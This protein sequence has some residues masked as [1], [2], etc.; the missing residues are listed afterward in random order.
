MGSGWLILT[1][2]PPRVTELFFEVCSE[3]FVVNVCKTS[4][5]RRPTSSVLHVTTMLE[6]CETHADV[7]DVCASPSPR[8]FSRIS[9]CVCMRI[10]LSMCA[11]VCMCVCVCVCC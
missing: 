6:A 8:H 9:A 3:P 7:Y 10:W 5:R 11:C 1:N 2:V 4:L